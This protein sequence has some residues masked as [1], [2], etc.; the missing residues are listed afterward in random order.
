MAQGEKE[1]SPNRKRVLAA[2]YFNG[3]IPNT[4][5]K[6][7]NL[8]ELRLTGNLIS[9]KIPDFLGNL[10][11]LITLDIEGTSM[12][13]PIPSSLSNLINLEYLGISDLNTRSIR[14]PNLT[15]LDNLTYLVLRNCSI[16]GPIPNF[17]GNF[18]NLKILDLSYNQLSGQIPDSMQT[19]PKP[20]YL[21]LTNNSLSGML[22][23]WILKTNNK[24]Y[25]DV[26][27]NNFSG[28]SDPFP[29][30]CQQPNVNL[31]A[32]YFSA[33]T[34][35]VPWCL[36]RNLP[37]STTPQYNNFSINCGGNKTSISNI[38]YDEDISP[39]G[40]STFFTNGEK[41]AYSST[42]VFLFT[43]S[44]NFLA[45]ETSNPN[46]TGIYRTARLAPLSLKYYGLCMLQGSYRVKLHFAEIVFANDET[47]SNNGRRVFDVAIQGDVKLKD[48]NIEAEAGGAGKEITKEFVVYVHGSTLEIS[49]YCH[50]N[51]EISKKLSAGVIVGIML[52][53]CALITAVLVYLW[54][55][56]GRDQEDNGTRRLA[57]LINLFASKSTTSFSYYTL[58]QIKMATEEFHD[59]NKIGEGGF[60]PV[61][62]GVLPN[63]K[64]IA[65][66]Q[67]SSKSKQGNR[68]FVNEIGMISAIQHPNL[69][70][71]YGCCIEGKELL[72]VY[73]YMENNCLAHALFGKENKKLHLDW[74]TR[75]K[76]VYLLDWAYM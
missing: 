16:T 57:T 27:Y 49:L 18:E 59:K 43:D 64:L 41:W 29:T 30:S 34:S 51:L 55:R 61:F 28:S 53:S 33:E 32:S 44:A 65:V 45:M 62:K 50:A 47:F 67:L 72:L 60:G 36:R 74:Q 46:V 3:T 13:G 2:N 73:E 75:K 40:H 14:F 26:S 48:F 11:N 8:T 42:G 38:E 17:V 23:S 1:G 20:N 25:V 22:P 9:G 24:H 39:G 10:T 56:G 68:E 12:E 19:M 6:L 31:A 21:F 52:A 70:K 5:V 7:R 63:G 76:F 35:S 69:V 71:L 58:R 54:M 37:C 15:K 4:F 66:K